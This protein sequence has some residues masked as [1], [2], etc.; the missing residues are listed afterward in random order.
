MGSELRGA[1]APQ[2]GGE[3]EDWTGWGL[4]DLAQRYARTPLPAG[5]TF[6]DDPL[7]VLRCAPRPPC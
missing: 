1:A 6:A 5:Q 7:R 4:S 2:E 3:V